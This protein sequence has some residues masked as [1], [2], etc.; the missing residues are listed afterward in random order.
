MATARPGT[1]T[2]ED[3]AGPPPSRVW[4]RADTLKRTRWQR[5]CAPYED[6]DTGMVMWRDDLFAV[7]DPTPD[8][9]GHLMITIVTEAVLRDWQAQFVLTRGPRPRPGRSWKARYLWVLTLEPD[10]QEA[11][12]VFREPT[13]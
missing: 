12:A 7:T 8:L 4:V 13:G 2:D 5:V 1:A 10:R 9:D 3:F 11:G 6:A